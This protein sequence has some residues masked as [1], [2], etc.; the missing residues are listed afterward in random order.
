MSEKGVELG[1]IMESSTRAQ[2]S[3]PLKKEKDTEPFTDVESGVRWLEENAY[4]V[5]ITVVNLFVINIIVAVYILPAD[6][7]STFAVITLFFGK[8]IFYLDCWI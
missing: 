5:K 2:D 7:F 6:F 3:Y 4:D 8:K 1:Y